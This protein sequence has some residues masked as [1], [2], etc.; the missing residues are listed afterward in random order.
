MGVDPSREQEER[1]DTLTIVCR[2][3]VKQG[4]GGG[5]THPLF[6]FEEHACRMI[7][8]VTGLLLAGGKSRRMGDDKRFLSIGERTMFERSLAALRPI[9]ENVLVVI[10]QDSLP[11]E[12]DVPVIRDL[13]PDRGSLG[14]L[15][16]GLRQAST[17]YVFVVA[18]DMPFLESSV[19]HYLAA[20]KGDA[21]I[22]MA[23]GESGVEPMHALYGRRCLPFLEKMINARR[24]TIQNITSHPSLR[25]RLISET[26]LR[27][28][29]P[30]GRSFLNVNTPADLDEARAMHARL[31][32]SSTS[33]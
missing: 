20:R 30:D 18:C 16:T 17:E 32:G 26:E 23:K 27:R 29:D 6:V 22:V 5:A 1:Q 7:T 3:S 9:F 31:T 11:M 21:D 15:Y 19:I 24:L 13:I 10:A 4:G 14:G 8:D 28:I 2:S 12:A 25:V 33:Q